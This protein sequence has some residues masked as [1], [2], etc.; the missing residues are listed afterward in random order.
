MFCIFAEYVNGGGSY[1]G[2]CAGAYYACARV[3]FEMGSELE[4]VG[5]RELAFFPGIGRGSVAPGEGA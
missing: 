5:E 2:L 3:E 4:V 1:L